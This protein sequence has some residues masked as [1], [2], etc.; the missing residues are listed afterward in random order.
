MQW[1][2]RDAELSA[3]LAPIEAPARVGLDTEFLRTDTYYPRLCLIQL[4]R[5]DGEIALIDPLNCALDPLWTLL[6]TPGI[7]TVA[8]AAFQDLEVLY[9]ASGGRL[10]A[11][12]FDTQI[13]ALLHRLGDRTGLAQLVER[14]CGET[15]A[16]DATR[17]DWCRRPL[18]ARQQ[19]YA[20][21]DV[22]HL[23]SLHARLTAPLTNAALNAL[24]EDFA[25]LLDPSRYAADPEHAWQRISGG[26]R[27]SAKQ[28]TLLR[29][30]AAWR[31][32][33]AQRHDLPRRWII[34]DDALLALAKRPPA[35]LAKLK[36]V[37][38]LT[39][40]QIKRWGEAIIAEIDR[41]FAEDDWERKQPRPRRT[42]SQ[43]HAL[44]LLGRAVIE[45]QADTFGF[46]ANAL[47]QHLPAF[48]HGD[49]T[50]L[51]RGWRR[52]LA[53]DPLRRIRDGAPVT[54]QQDQLKVPHDPIFKT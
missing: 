43:H 28:H 4:A 54:V 2:D 36:N 46:S 24:E 8:H 23:L 44:H 1:I 18:D 26:Q 15:L 47:Q 21:D 3:F 30:L 22:R 42:S 33:T 9:Q 17:T 6:T 49:A 48:F 20:A 27:F 53:G 52:L 5:E 13:A 40:P 31:E 50:P 11:R 14:F 29:R 25:D 12:L 19:A 10:P 34:G 45:Q 37:P 51:D 38:G 35:A 32:Q 7:T 41:A 39:P 16:K